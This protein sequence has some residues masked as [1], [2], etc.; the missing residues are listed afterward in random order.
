MNPLYDCDFVAWADQTV[1][2]LR[3]HRWEELDL[4]NLIEEVEDLGNRHRDALRSQLTRLLMHLL[5]WHYQTTSFRG[6]GSWRNSINEA[7]K[8]IR[9]LQKQYPSLVRSTQEIFEVCYPDA[10]EDASDETGIPEKGFPST[11]PFTL[12]QVLD[13]TY[14]PPQPQDKI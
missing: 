7:R 2:L 13:P 9:R 8:Q 6:E 5:K 10:V 11:C 12:E 14:L 3:E 1:Q 4:E